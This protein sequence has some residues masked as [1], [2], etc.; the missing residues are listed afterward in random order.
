MIIILIV[1]GTFTLFGLGLGRLHLYFKRNAKTLRASIYAIER[2][3]SSSRRKK[4][5]YYRPLIKYTFE[6]QNYIFSSNFGSSDLKYRINDQVKVLSLDKGA[7]YVRLQSRIQWL[8]PLIF[9]V[10]G[11]LGSLIYFY[12]NPSFIIFSIYL[13]ALALI[14]TMLYR[15]LK[16]KNLLDKFIETV[17][18]AKI[19]DEISM[20]DREIFTKK[21]ELKQHLQ[22]NKFI[23]LIITLFFLLATSTGL[24]FSWNKTKLSSKEYFFD[25]MSNLELI[26]QLEK[27][28]QDKNLL[29]SL[30]LIVFTALLL[31]SLLYQLFKKR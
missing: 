4:S 31:Y 6:G 30:I 16:S 20:K 8:F 14:P 27:F 15:Y 18:K 25:L 26:N 22:K 10:S 17:L 24:H 29:L 1:C 12:K 5:T 21:R 11:T 3:Q 2:Y 28:I 23:G 19:E 13:T 9:F 7:E